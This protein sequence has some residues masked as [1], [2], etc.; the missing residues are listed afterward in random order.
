MYTL[1]DVSNTCGIEIFFMVEAILVIV[2]ST[3]RLIAF[4][5]EKCILGLLRMSQFSF[6]MFFPENGAHDVDLNT[7]KFCRETTEPRWKCCQI[8]LSKPL[9]V[10]DLTKIFSYVL[11]K[12]FTDR[13]RLTSASSGFIV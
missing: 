6:T 1:S 10:S 11:L 5:T 8:P 13:R 12:I 4:S 3:H 7:E 9:N 2:N